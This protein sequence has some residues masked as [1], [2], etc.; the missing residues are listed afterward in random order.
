MKP[1]SLT[2]YIAQLHEKDK[3]DFFSYSLLQSLSNFISCT[4]QSRHRNNDDPQFVLG[5]GF[6]AGI[7][8]NGLHWRLRCIGGGKLWWIKAEEAAVGFRAYM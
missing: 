7:A 4:K 1:N 3:K 2:Q 8:T 6:L 5:I